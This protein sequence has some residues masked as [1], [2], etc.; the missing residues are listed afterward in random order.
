M[1]YACQVFIL[2][3]LRL[4]AK[5]H[6]PRHADAMRRRWHR[7]VVVAIWSHLEIVQKDFNP[8]LNFSLSS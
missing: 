1:H 2:Q 6:R 8:I 7:I 4:S 5:L 3:P